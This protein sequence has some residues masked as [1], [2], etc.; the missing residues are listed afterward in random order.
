MSDLAE[1][2]TYTPASTALDAILPIFFHP[3]RT[4][5]QNIAAPVHPAAAVLLC[6]LANSDAEGGLSE[7]RMKMNL[8][9]AFD[10][11]TAAEVVAAGIESVLKTDLV[12]SYL[13]AGANNLRYRLTA[14]GKAMMIDTLGSV[15]KNG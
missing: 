14:G 6:L 8:R 13:E 11:E 1:H 3:S 10:R 4:V 5:A 7:T 12:E 2:P 9:F 15:F